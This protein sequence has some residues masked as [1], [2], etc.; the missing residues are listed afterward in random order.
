VVA[1][2]KLVL[3]HPD[4][5]FT[6]VGSVFS[7]LAIEGMIATLKFPG[8]PDVIHAPDAFASGNVQSVAQEAIVSAREAIAERSGF[9]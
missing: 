6:A 1:V 2:P 7:T 3:L 9:Q 8:S 5:R 4:G